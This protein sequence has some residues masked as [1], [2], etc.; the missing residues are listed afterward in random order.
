MI[1]Y[2]L[3]SNLINMGYSHCIYL[4]LK[5]GKIRRGKY[6]VYKM[7]LNCYYKE[8]KNIDKVLLKMNN[9]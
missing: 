4:E 5:V 7:G 2:V 8:V 3:E 6:W 1:H 9:S